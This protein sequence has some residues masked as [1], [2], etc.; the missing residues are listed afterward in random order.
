MDNYCDNIR[1]TIFKLNNF[2]ARVHY[3]R[4]KAHPTG[5]T[6]DIIL[7]DSMDNSITL[8]LNQIIKE[9]SIDGEVLNIKIVT[10]GPNI[11]LLKIK[12]NNN[13]YIIKTEEML[14]NYIGWKNVWEITRISDYCSNMIP[15]IIDNIEGD[16][17]S[18]L[19]K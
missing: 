4:N 6:S 7:I 2:E 16:I 17:S 10:Y 18:V 15:W 9:C 8:H 1:D 12:F 5:Y 19:F 13:S 11:Y 3:T 14:Y